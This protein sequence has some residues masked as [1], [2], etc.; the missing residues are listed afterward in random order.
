MNGFNVALKDAIDNF[1]F[2]VVIEFMR[3]HNWKWPTFVNG[4]FIS[5]NSHYPD[6]KEM[7][8]HIEGLYKT[9]LYGILVDGEV[10]NRASSG[11]FT[12]E[13]NNAYD[14][15]QVEITFDIGSYFGEEDD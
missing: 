15:P 13:L 3:Q 12:I 10:R 5:R 7:I 8:K 4:E 14:E 6:Q 1:N 2:K 9:C 11:G